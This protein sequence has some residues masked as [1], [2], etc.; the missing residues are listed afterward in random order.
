[1]RRF[2]RIWERTFMR[3][4][5]WPAVRCAVNACRTVL[6][7]LFFP[8]WW[9]LLVLVERLDALMARRPRAFGFA[10]SVY[11]HVVLIGIGIAIWQHAGHGRETLPPR[12]GRPFMATDL[13]EAALAVEQEHEVTL[14]GAWDADELESLDT[15]LRRLPRAMVLP[16][17][18][19]TISESA[20]HFYDP[21]VSN[22]GA[23][24]HARSGNICYRPGSARFHDTHWHECG[25]AYAESLGKAFWA[26][27]DELMGDVYGQSE[28]TEAGDWVWKGGG[29]EP[30]NGI[31]TPYGGRNAHEHIA[32][33][34]EACYQTLTE[35]WS[36]IDQL[37]SYTIPELKAQGKELDPRFERMAKFLHKWKFLNDEDA[38]LLRTYL[39]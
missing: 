16:A 26:E 6:R 9:P 20:A 7:W 18:I 33:W 15:A 32:E 3:R 27:L 28:E 12:E 10:M 34:V 29:T 30:R 38:E 24:C 11:V 22:P 35:H 23:H 19:L 2:S 39:E 31:L 21:E 14:F 37:R 1:M 17:N 13:R 25:H 36:P 8:V 5:P 4:R